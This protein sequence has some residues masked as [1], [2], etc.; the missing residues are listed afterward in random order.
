M[1]LKGD[2]NPALCLYRVL[3]RFDNGKVDREVQQG[4]EGRKP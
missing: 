2:E 1:L 4:L 3:I